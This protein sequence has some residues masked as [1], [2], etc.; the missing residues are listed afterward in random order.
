MLPLSTAADQSQ[1]SKKQRTNDAVEESSMDNIVTFDVGGKIFK[2]SRSCLQNHAGIH[3]LERLVSD[4]WQKDKDHTKPIF[5]DRDGDTF[6]YVLNY[7]RYGHVTLPATVLPEDMFLLDLDFY[8]IEPTEDS[9]RSANFLKEKNTPTDLVTFDVGGRIFKTKESVTKTRSKYMPNDETEM[10]RLVAKWQKSDTTQPLFI[11]R[12]PDVFAQILNYL[13]FGKVTLPPN[14]P[15]DV[16]YEDL[17][18]FIGLTRDTE[19]VTL[20]V[21]RVDIGNTELHSFLAAVGRKYGIDSA[22]NRDPLDDF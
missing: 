13:R 12:D 16:F 2:T 5:I 17:G 21:Q 18:Y 15:E 1:A 3:M 19:N 11:D 9:V 10:E 7:L 6:A 14:I 20:S 4:T 8:G 22:Y